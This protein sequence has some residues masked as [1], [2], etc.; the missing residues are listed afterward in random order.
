MKPVHTPHAPEPAGHYSQGMVHQG[1]V[2]VAGQLPFHPERP[3]APLGTVEE[4]TRRTLQNVEAV[5]QAA[6]SGLDRL[7]EVT[8]YVADL[9]HWGT[10]NQV[11]AEMLGDHRPARAVVPVGPLKRGALLEIQ[12]RATVG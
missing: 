1:V 11:Y 9:A 12:A 2:Y 7:L 3:D 4:Q 10:I 5:L 6:G 8:V